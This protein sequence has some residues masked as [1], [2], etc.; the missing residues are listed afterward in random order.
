MKA[1]SNTQG[2]KEAGAVQVQQTS[3]VSAKGS[4]ELCV[5][6]MDPKETLALAG[7]ANNE[8][9]LFHVV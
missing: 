6:H 7:D 3:L 2:V 9:Y 4:S 8:P 1:T 5:Q